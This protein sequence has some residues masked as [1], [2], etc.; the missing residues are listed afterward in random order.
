MDV[1]TARQLQRW[2]LGL[3]WIQ[4]FPGDLVEFNASMELMLLHNEKGKLINTE[5]EVF[6]LPS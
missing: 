5:K 3:A 6:Q 4:Y 1:A 2:P